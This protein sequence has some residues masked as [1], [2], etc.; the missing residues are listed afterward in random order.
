MADITFKLVE[1]TCPALARR[2]A[3]PW[4]RRYPRPPAQEGHRRRPFMPAAG[5]SCPFG[6]LARL[7]EQSSGLSMAAIMPVATPGVARGSVEL[8]VT[9]QRWMMRMSVA[10]LE[11]VGR[12]TVRSACSV[13]SS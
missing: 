10:A 9:Q 2:H 4:P 1:V 13:P 6:L 3:G 11:Q 12:E 5:L 7:R 8:L